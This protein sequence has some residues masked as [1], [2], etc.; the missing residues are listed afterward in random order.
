MYD[1]VN[2]G[3]GYSENGVVDRAVY[4]AIMAGK[5][6]PRIRGKVLAELTNNGASRGFAASY[7][8]WVIV[9]IC[10]KIYNYHYSKS[11]FRSSRT[12]RMILQAD[13]V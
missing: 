13:L 8:L 11:G 4:G 7:N 5:E 1:K 2:T 12:A 3:V 9:G 6:K 10:S